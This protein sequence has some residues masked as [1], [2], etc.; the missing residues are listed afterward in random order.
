MNRLR[1]KYLKEI[2][3]TL[4]EQYKIDNKLA[5]PRLVK[6]IVNVGVTDQQHRDKSIENVSQQIAAIT[7]QQPAKRVAR[8]SIAGFKLRQGDPVG[9]TVTLRGDRMYQFLDKV[10][11]IVLPQVK[12]FQGVPLNSFDGNGNYNF[13]LKEQIIFPEIDYDKIDQIRGMQITIVTSTSVDEQSK[14]L[15][16]LLGMPFQKIEE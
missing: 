7:G 1:Q 9:V 8:K 3:P 5:L 12:D 14:D 4:K 11:S 2:T 16:T 13:G 15:L 6:V 10:I